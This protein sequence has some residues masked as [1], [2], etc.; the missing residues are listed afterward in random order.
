[1]PKDNDNNKIKKKR[2]KKEGEV[3]EVKTEREL[4]K[5]IKTYV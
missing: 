5:Y 2:R 4:S 1:V 3:E